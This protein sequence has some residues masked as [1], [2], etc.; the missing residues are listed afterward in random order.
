MLQQLQTRLSDTDIN[1][2]QV[3]KEVSRVDKD[4]EKLN[5]EFRNCIRISSEISVKR[6]CKTYSTGM[7]YCSYI[8]LGMGTKQIAHLLNVEPKSVRM[9]KYRLK[10][11]FGLDEDTDLDTFFSVTLGSTDPDN[12]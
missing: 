4:F 9:A 10:K 7:K 8:Y 11:K 6:H 3:V 12:I 5:S 1:I 2:N